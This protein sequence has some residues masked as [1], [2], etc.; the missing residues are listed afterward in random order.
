MEFEWLRVISEGL[1]EISGALRS[2]TEFH[3]DV[4]T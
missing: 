1:K 4:V 2:P 3:V